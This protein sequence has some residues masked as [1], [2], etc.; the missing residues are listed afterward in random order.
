[1]KLPYKRTPLPAGLHDYFLYWFKGNQGAVE[2]ATILRSIT[3]TWDDLI[4]KDPVTD[5][6]INGAFF[7]ALIGLT[8]NPF[9]LEH[10]VELSLL[11][12]VAIRDWFDSNALIES[13]QLEAAYT[14]RCS[15]ST[16]FTQCAVIT[17]G[18]DWAQ[19]MSTDYRKILF[20]DFNKFKEEHNGLEQ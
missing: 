13:G 5:E 20:D 2:F 15:L 18:R 1:M 10:I 4:D 9:Y 3:D 17:G 8:K 11:L 14:L 6:L 12:E 7:D 19:L 16:V